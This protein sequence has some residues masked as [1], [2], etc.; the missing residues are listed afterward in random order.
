MSGIVV[1]PNWSA[2]GARGVVVLAQKLL[3]SISKFFLMNNCCEEANVE[4]Q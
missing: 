3:Y 2:P 1:E 4:Y